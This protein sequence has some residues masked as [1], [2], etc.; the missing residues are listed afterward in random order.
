VL[1]VEWC[2]SSVVDYCDGKA[3]VETR[4]GGGCGSCMG[5]SR[6]RLR[7]E[8]LLLLLLLLLGPL[9]CY[10]RRSDLLAQHTPRRVPSQTTVT[11]DI[12]KIQPCVCF[13]HFPRALAFAPDSASL[14]ARAHPAAASRPSNK[15]PSSSTTTT[16]IDNPAADI[17]Y[18]RLHRRSAIVVVADS[19]P[20]F[21]TSRS[22]HPN[23]IYAA[24]T[25]RSRRATWK[26]CIATDPHITEGVSANNPI[27]LVDREQSL[28]KHHSTWLRHCALAGSHLSLINS[29]NTQW[30]Q[31]MPKPHHYQHPRTATLKKTMHT[32]LHHFHRLGV[33]L[34]PQSLESEHTAAPKV[35][36]QAQP[37]YIAV[38]AHP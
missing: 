11:V 8:L 21:T 28:S 23:C 14:H 20:L 24:S 32:R 2:F 10:S 33:R 29:N 1:V 13:S 35:R 37:P 36:P 12:P 34:H 27:R 25:A 7:M 31:P 9:T 26:L 19:A 6:V 22:S 16:P 30:R 15:R 38:A 17:R 5:R 4:A 3:L 18:T